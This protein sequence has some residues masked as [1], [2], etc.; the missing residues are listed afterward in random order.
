MK[1]THFLISS[2]MAPEESQIGPYDLRDFLFFA[3]PKLI[4]PIPNGE[5]PSYQWVIDFQDDAKKLTD[6]LAVFSG[7]SEELE[8]FLIP[9]KLFNAY[10]NNQFA[11]ILDVLPNMSI[12][13]MYEYSVKKLCSPA[14]DK[15][16]VYV[17][18]DID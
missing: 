1:L 4:I 5:R 2:T 10:T 12:M 9:L 14:Q 7:S 16:Y 18:V 17:L 11:E 15:S 13:K 8:N 3:R 6:E